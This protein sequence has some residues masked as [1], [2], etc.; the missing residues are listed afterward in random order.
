MIAYY[1]RTAADLGDADAQKELAG[2]YQNGEGVKQDRALAACYHRMAALKGRSEFGETWVYK[3]KYTEFF[4]E[5]FPAY[6]RLEREQGLSEGLPINPDAPLEL[7]SPLELRSP[8]DV[9][10]GVGEQQGPRSPMLNVLQAVH[11]IIQ[12]ERRESRGD[13]SATIAIAAKGQNPPS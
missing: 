12:T 1:F 9:G 7:Q 11:G 2:C 3:E 6:A 8:I 5:N 13:L 4:R 10:V